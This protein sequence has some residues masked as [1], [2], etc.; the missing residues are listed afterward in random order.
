[1]ELVLTCR[2]CGHR[3]AGDS[4]NG[5]MS[6]IKMWNHVSRAHADRAIEASEVRLLIKQDNKARIAEEAYRLQ[7]SY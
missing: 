5:L 4:R 2:E 7:A 3:E 1:M 6:R